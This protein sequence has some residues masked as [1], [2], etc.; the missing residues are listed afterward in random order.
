[1]FVQMEELPSMYSRPLV[2]RSNAPRPST[3]TNGSCSGLHHS[4]MSVNGC[5]TNRLSQ[6]I[7]SSVFQSVMIAFGVRRHV[8]AFSKRRHVCALHK[9]TLYHGSY[10]DDHSLPHSSCIS[11]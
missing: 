6:A 9:I 2:S 5:Q 10:V 11:F 8:A 7:S 4:R 1:M 3:K